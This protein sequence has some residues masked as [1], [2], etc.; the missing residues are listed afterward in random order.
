MS[1]MLDDVDNLFVSLRRSVEL[2]ARAPAGVRCL[3]G[4]GR[5]PVPIPPPQVSRCHRRRPSSACY[6]LHDV[7]RSRFAGVHGFNTTV[8]RVCPSCVACPARGRNW[9]FAGTCRSVCFPA[10]RFP[11]WIPPLSHD[12]A[13]TRQNTEFAALPERFEGSPSAIRHAGSGRQAERLASRV[14]AR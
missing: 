2:P 11:A 8:R 9:T 5:D 4:T 10:G 12:G 7:T 1:L 6:C 13:M 14:R 3:S